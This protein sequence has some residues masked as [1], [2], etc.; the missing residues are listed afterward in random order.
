[1]APQNQFASNNSSNSNVFGQ[2][3]INK[4]FNQGN[5]SSTLQNTPFIS[6]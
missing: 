6:S 1:M 5:N 4:N 2:N 3:S